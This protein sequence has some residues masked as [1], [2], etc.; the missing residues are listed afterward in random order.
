MEDYKNIDIDLESFDRRF[1]EAIELDYSLESA[2]IKRILGRIILPSLK[3]LPGSPDFKLASKILTN[4]KQHYLNFIIDVI[5]N[6]ISY[7]EIM[8]A[9]SDPGTVMERVFGDCL[10][11]IFATRKELLF[12]KYYGEGVNLLKRE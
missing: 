7:E 5:P 10:K 3:V 4:G 11:D 1:Q 12:K 2:A 9:L 8:L 6:L